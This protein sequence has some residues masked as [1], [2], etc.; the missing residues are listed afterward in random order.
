MKKE[1]AVASLEQAG[2]TINDLYTR[3]WATALYPTQHGWG[4][5]IACMAAIP[6]LSMA[7]IGRLVS[8][9]VVEQ[10]PVEVFDTVSNF[11]KPKE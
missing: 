4:P 7:S 6:V 5:S 8:S 9:A 11:G 10:L 1:E 2:E 3:A